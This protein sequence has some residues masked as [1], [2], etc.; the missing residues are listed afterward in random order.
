MDIAEL[1]LN[2]L[3]SISKFETFY[4]NVFSKCF[5]LDEIGSAQSYLWLKESEKSSRGAFEYHMTFA[6]EAGKY[7]ACFIYSWF[8]KICSIAAE[9][10][11]VDERH[12]GKGLAKMLM[13]C[14]EQKHDFEWMFGEVES[15]NQ[16]NRAIWHRYGFR[17]VPV[18]YKQLSLE[19][20]RSQVDNLLLCVYSKAGLDQISLATV[21][22]FI[23]H[24]YR[25][26]QFC[27]D[28]DSTDTIQAIDQ[29]SSANNMLRLLPLH[30]VTY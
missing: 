1:D 4:N 10:A 23:W 6:E 30:A 8:P 7:T 15:F 25:Y 18:Q 19:E 16:T 29:L 26:S 9:F 27:T 11:C 17:L 24:Y 5:P 3:H 20:D 12:R 28:P 22:S 14:A 2:D 13:K 21:R